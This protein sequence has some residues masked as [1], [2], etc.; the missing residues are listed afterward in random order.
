VPGTCPHRATRTRTPTSRNRSARYRPHHGI[1]FD[2]EEVTSSILVSPTTHDRPL[3]SGRG[4]VVVPEPRSVGKLPPPRPR[5]GSRRCD[6]RSRSEHERRSGI[7]LRVTECARGLPRETGEELS[8]VRRLGEA[9]P[10]ADGG[11][12]QVGVGQQTL[13]LQPC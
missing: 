6:P 3:T 9:E 12:R 4:P 8:E 7:R 13:S 2:T 11:D 5:A 1:R 10:T